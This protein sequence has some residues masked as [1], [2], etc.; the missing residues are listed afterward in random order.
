MAPTSVLPAW[1]AEAFDALVAGDVDGWARIYAPDAVH[2]LP[3]A[4][5]GQVRRLEGRETIAARLK[6]VFDSGE[7]RLRFGSFDDV[8][9]REIGDEIVI[10][11]NGRHYRTD[12]GTP[13]EI[14]CVWFITR[15][16]GQVTHFR[17]YMNPLPLSAHRL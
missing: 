16:D 8:R 3:F 7:G 9:V 17:D 6:E 11:G 14:G 4:P 12:D 2:E 10:E 5:E 13:V 1:L 15:R